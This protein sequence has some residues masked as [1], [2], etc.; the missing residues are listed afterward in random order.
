MCRSALISS[1]FIFLF[2][3]SSSQNLTKHV[4][5]FIGT[6]GHGHTY[7]GASMPFG[8]MQLSPDTRLTGWDGCSGYHDSDSIIYGFTHTHLSGTGVSDYGDILLMPFK[9]SEL[10][11]NPK[12]QFSKKTEKAQPGYYS[13]Q[14]SD[15]NILVELA[16]TDRAGIHKYVFEDNTTNLVYLDL[17]HRDKVLSSELNIENE[18]TISGFRISEAWAKEQHVYFVAEFSEKFKNIGG[19]ENHNATLE[20]NTKEVS[21][22]IGISAVSVEG[23]RKNLQA[24]IPHWDFEKVKTDATTTWENELSKIEIEATKD[25]LEIFYTALYHSLLNP[26]LFSDTDGQYRGT[27]LKIHETISNVYTVFS[28]WDTYRAT[29]PLFTIIEQE[30]TNEFI[31]T[32]LLQYENGGQLPMWELSGNYTG[33]MIGYHSIPVITDAYMKK[34]RDYDTDK[35]YAACLATSKQ[36]KL[37]LGAYQKYGYIAATEEHESVSKA[38]EYAYDDWCIAQ[39]ANDKKDS[40]SYS[41]YSKRAQ[42]YKNHYDPQT[43]FMRAKRNEVFMEPFNPKEVN[44]NF[45]EANSWQYSFYAPQDVTGLIELMGGKTVFDEKLDELFSAD[46]KTTGRTQVD[47]T[48][49]VGQ[50]AHGNEPSHHMA[51][52]YSFVNKPWKTQKMVRH[53][54]SEMYTAKPDGLIGNED[55]GQ[56]SSWYVLSAMGFY[57]VTPGDTNYTIG[58]PSISSGV[59]NLENGK[60]FN[61]EVNNQSEENVYIQSAMLNGAPYSKSYLSHFDIMNGGSIEFTMGNTPNEKWGSGEL[62]IP[63]TNISTEAITAVPFI[64]AENQTFADS[65]FIEMSCASNDSEILYTVNNGNELQYTNGFYI[66]ET[67]NIKA[68]SN[69]PLSSE[70]FS[71]NADFYKISGKRSILIN[72]DCDPQYTAGGNN[73]LLDHIRGGND[74]RTG[75]W[76]GYQGNDFEAIVDLGEIQDIQ[77]IS[78]G[79]IQDLRSWIVMPTEIVYSISEDGKKFN[80]VARIK[81]TYSSDSYEV[82]AIDYE[83]KLITKARY[84]KVNATYFGKLPEWHLGAGGESYIFIDEIIIE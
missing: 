13:V 37:G 14:L 72:S 31:N 38:L 42:Y 4:N 11:S 76:Q 46:N 18:T 12:S 77:S 74:F 40:K 26:N 34:I 16:T 57:P 33:C 63:S 50:Y 29:H 54:L 8:M 56:M 52:L 84:V 25:E 15:N 30:K 22:R 60:S 55:C 17:D 75:A 20:F 61:I 24:E 69:S 83:H 21:I 6:G 68:K 51:Y 48:G 35:I 82:K 27:D 32:F 5:P 10:D 41:E 43:G 3:H 53:L 80:E 81:Q 9:K 64:I 23:A 70:S 19:T 44:F 66:A 45:T 67:S 1:L 65:L 36:E 39:M 78:S 49:L 71:I 79:Y 58:S 2:L 73:S 7:P 59:I 62:E 47:I 28:L